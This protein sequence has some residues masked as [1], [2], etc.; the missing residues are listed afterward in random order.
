M[1]DKTLKERSSLY[2]S[3]SELAKKSKELQKIV[4]ATEDDV[5]N[6]A[7]SL[8]CHKLARISNGNPFYIDNWRDIA[9]YASLVVQYLE[10]ESEEAVDTNV[11]KRQK[12]KGE[13][14]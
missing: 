7:L 2:G 13:W 11:I 12:I 4:G 5:I 6:E 8:I 14:Q 1:I 9:G 3:F 10:S